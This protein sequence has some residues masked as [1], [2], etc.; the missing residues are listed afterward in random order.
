M[1]NALTDRMLLDCA[2]AE[3]GITGTKALGDR[4]LALALLAAY[5]VDVDR[6][7]VGPS[8]P[9]PLR[10]ASTKHLVTRARILADDFPRDERSDYPRTKA[11]W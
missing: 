3:L 8:D 5:E 7:L 1:A 6:V 9:T 2:A 4:E 11:V 10:Q